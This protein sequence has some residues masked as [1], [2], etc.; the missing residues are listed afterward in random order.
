MNILQALQG[1]EM[2]NWD[3]GQIDEI[4][5]KRTSKIVHLDSGGRMFEWIMQHSPRVQWCV[6]MVCL[7]LCQ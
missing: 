5:G 7:C 6:A 4:K 2:M 3:C 1:K